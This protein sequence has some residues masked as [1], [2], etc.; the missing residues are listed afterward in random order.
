MG[1]GKTRKALYAF[2]Y[3]K[4]VRVVQR[5]LVVAPLSTLVPVWDA[6]IFSVFGYM[7]TAVLH[8]SKRQ[9]LKY[10]ATNPDIAI[11]NHEGVEIILDALIAWKPDIVVIDELAMYRT[12]TTNRWKAMNALV[13]NP[14]RPVPFAW[15]LTGRPIPNAPTDSYGQIKLFHPHK[16]PRSTVAYRSQLMLQV[17]RF[18]WVPKPDANKQV[19]AL[20]QP[21]VRYSLDECH[22]IPPMTFTDRLVAMRPQQARLYNNLLRSN[23]TQY[24]GGQISAVNEGVLLNKLLQVSAGFV[25]DD[26]KIVRFVGS[27]DRFRLVLELIAEANK[28]V[29]VFSTYKGACLIL[30]QLVQR[31][32]SAALITGDTKRSERDLTIASFRNSRDPHVIV[33][34]QKTM[35]HG[36]TAVEA[37]TI[38]WVGPTMSSEQY[39]QANAR[40]RRAGQTAHTHVVHVYS[41]DVERKAFQRLQRRQKLQGLLLSMFEE[42]RD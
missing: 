15:G 8:G 23:Y 20:M 6:E 28:K 22:D 10:L 4:Q 9:R 25:Y 35:A 29:L 39:D 3:L 1:T 30:Y 18:K 38:I 12:H 40:I 7:K 26:K 21:S 24:K 34:H 42:M 16:L 32:Y 11:I 27:Q 14:R 37:D 36:L 2:D 33:A 5:M 31:K 41:S 19:F 13:N 17:S